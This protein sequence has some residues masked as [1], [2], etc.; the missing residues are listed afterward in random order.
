MRFILVLFGALIAAYALVFDT[1]LSADRQ[2]AR[3]EDRQREI[4]VAASTT[5]Y[6]GS[7]V[8]MDADGYLIPAADTAG[9]SVVGVADEFVDNS[10]GSDGDLNCRV[11]TG[12]TFRFAA[13]SITQAMVGDLM[14][15][16]DDQTFD[17]T[18]SNLVAVGILIAFISTTEGWILMTPFAAS[19]AAPVRD[20]VTKTDDYTVLASESGTVFAIATDAKVFT[21]PATAAGLFYTFV[22]TGADGAVLLSISPA[23]ADAIMFVTSVDDKDLLNTK[24]TAVEGDAVTI[25]G[26]G[27]QGWVVVGAP[28]GTWA[29]E[30]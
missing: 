8:M 16:I 21:L 25:F 24:A 7:M 30:S 10:G 15:A 20:F 12:G 3:R 13:S 11:L 18:S 2:T 28:Q 1:V 27:G 6:K 26:D 29:K 4:P 14:Y 9:L 22:N 23:A 19:V 5:I 17:N